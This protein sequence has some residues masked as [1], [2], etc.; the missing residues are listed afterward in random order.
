MMQELGIFLHVLSI[1][2]CVA[3]TSLGV[4]IG[5]GLAHKA[6]YMRSTLPQHKAPILF[7]RPLLG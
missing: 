4:G 5:G 6:H 1:V 3:A 7:V 2:F